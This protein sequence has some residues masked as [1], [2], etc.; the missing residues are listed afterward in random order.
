MKTRYTSI[1]TF[2]KRLAERDFSATTL[3]ALKR[4]GVKVVSSLMIGT[5]AEGTECVAYGIDDG[6]TYRILR[7][8]EVLALI[9]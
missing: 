9:S 5:A 1:D 3:A 2:A 8:R 4:K 6:D 7:H